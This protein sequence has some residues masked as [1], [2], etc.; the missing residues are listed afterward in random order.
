MNY[1]KNL[2]KHTSRHQSG[3]SY[4]TNIEQT[5]LANLTSMRTTNSQLL[6]LYMIGAAQRHGN[7]RNANT[8]PPPPK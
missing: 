1:N 4:K 5:Q 6:F 2:P 8:D 3:K 7:K